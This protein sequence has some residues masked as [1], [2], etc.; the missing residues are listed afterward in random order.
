[1]IKTNT[2]KQ[3]DIAGTVGTHPVYLNAVLRGRSRPS[4][5]LALRIQEATGG[6]YTVMELLFQKRKPPKK[7]KTNGGRPIRNGRDN[8]HTAPL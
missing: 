2:F 7:R 6:A 3:I 4:P 5:D 1:M 8:R